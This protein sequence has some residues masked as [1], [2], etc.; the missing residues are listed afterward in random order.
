MFAA[1]AMRVS[2]EAEPLMVATDG[3][4]LGAVMRVD[5]GRAGESITTRA[6][7]G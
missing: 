4:V 2:E 7:P 3:A 1:L 5:M 6:A